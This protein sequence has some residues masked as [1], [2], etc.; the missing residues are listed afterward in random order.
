LLFAVA[1][2]FAFAVF[3]CHPVGICFCLCRRLFFCLPTIKTVILSE[4]VRA[5]EPRS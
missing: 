3:A 4:V 5:S 2:A 1:F